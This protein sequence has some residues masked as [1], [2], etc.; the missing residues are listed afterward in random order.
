MPKEPKHEVWTPAEASK[1]AIDS[2]AEITGTDG[3]GIAQVLFDVTVAPFLGI[4][5]GGVGREPVHLDLGMCA[6][7]LFDDSRAMGIEPIPNND[8]GT[9]NV[10]LEVA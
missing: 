6:N 9:R 1:A 8:E 5:I 2:S 7:V 3:Y 4:Q 10:S